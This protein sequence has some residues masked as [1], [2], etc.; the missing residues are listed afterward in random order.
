MLRKLPVSNRPS[1]A[2]RNAVRS[3]TAKCRRA[4]SGKSEAAS[5]AVY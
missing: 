5:S 3:M 4:I 2:A 1:G